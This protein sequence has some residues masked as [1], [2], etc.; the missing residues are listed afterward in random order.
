[1]QNLQ[2]LILIVLWTIPAAAAVN[3][4]FPPMVPTL[5]TTLK[6]EEKTAKY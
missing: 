2:L 6:K 4:V 5:C 1:M 3:A